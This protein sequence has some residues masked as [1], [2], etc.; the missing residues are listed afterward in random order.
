MDSPMLKGTQGDGHPCHQEAATIELHLLACGDWHRAQGIKK[1]K[2]DTF[3]CDIELEF[4]K[5]G[6][7]LG[8]FKLFS[9]RVWKI[10]F[11]DRKF[12]SH[13]TKSAGTWLNCIITTHKRALS[14]NSLFQ[15]CPLQQEQNSTLV[16][17]HSRY[18][19]LSNSVDFI[20][21]RPLF[22]SCSEAWFLLSPLSIDVTSSCRETCVLKTRTCLQPLHS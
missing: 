1:K 17:R 13:F 2:N 4:L 8:F 21:L 7:P 5:A 18:T 11:P 10:L 15:S 12:D 6:K 14:R 16:F 3:P 19:M 9:T 20:F 22:G